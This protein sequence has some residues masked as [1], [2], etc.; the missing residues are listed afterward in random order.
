M[1]QSN[2]HSVILSDLPL[3]TANPASMIELAIPSAGSKLQGFM[4]QAAGKGYHPTLFLLHGFPGN[5]RN[6]DL[7]QVVRSKG[8]NVVY[9]NYRGAWGSQGQFS[10]K[11]CVEDVVNAVHYLKQEKERLKVDV[12]HLVLFGHSMGGW[13]TLKAVQQ[14]PEIKKAFVL[15]TWDIPATFKG[16]QSEAALM[17]RP[18]EEFKDV[19]VLNTSYKNI[20]TPIIVNPAYYDLAKD[21]TQLVG[22]QIVVLDEHRKNEHIVNAIKKIN[23]AAVEYLI[24]ETDHSFTNK[25]ASLIHKVLDFLKKD[26]LISQEEISSNEAL[27]QPIIGFFDGLSLIREDL[28]FEH[29]TKDFVLLEAGMIWNNDTLINRIRP[30]KNTNFERKN[31]FTFLSTKQQGN[32]AWVSYWNQ[33]T[34]NRNGKSSTLK[35]LES[36]VLVR[37]MGRW[38][39]QLM[40]STPMK[41]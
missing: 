23:P 34:I 7:A 13:V 30:L 33:A 39:I 31:S 28:L 20:I 8:W 29:T 14:L 40:H 41:Q 12:N 15:S 16:I 35:W 19:F 32:V 18:L 24:W 27:H 17:A 1:A 2:N 11:N 9:F 21:A 3:D 4:Y 5:E 36:V 6:L 38:K 26:Q 37:E 22:K 25:R 10:F